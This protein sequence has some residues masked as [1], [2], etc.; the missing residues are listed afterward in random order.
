MASEETPYW[1]DKN[2][3]DNIAKHFF[4]AEPGKK[5]YI[6]IPPNFKRGMHIKGL[7][8]IIA[9]IVDVETMLFHIFLRLGKKTI[10]LSPYDNGKMADAENPTQIDWYCEVIGKDGYPI[11]RGT[12]MECPLICDKWLIYDTKTLFT[13][14]KVSRENVTLDSVFELEYDRKDKTTY[15]ALSYDINGIKRVECSGLS[16][17]SVKNTDRGYTIYPAKC[18]NFGKGEFEEI[19]NRISTSNEYIFATLE[20]AEKKRHE[21]RLKATRYL[22]FRY[23]DFRY[24]DFLGKCEWCVKFVLIWLKNL[25]VKS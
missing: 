4:Y 11:M 15:R 10:V 3:C 22:N 25:V 23:N 1:E 9:T 17:F 21:F 20:D 13:P 2:F 14:I 5:V 7:A 19:N 24:S 12:K 18:V 6:D 8:T 16:I